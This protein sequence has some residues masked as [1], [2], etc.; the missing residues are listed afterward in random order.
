MDLRNLLGKL[1]LIEGT[2]TSAEK[3]S[4]GPKFTGQWKGTDA[5]TPGKK[6][7][8]DSI[9]KD[10]SKGPKPKT[11][12]Q[13]LAEQFE[14]FL[15]QLEEDN[16][17]VE[18]KRPARKG[19]RPAREYTKNGQP[20]KRYTPVKEDGEENDPHPYTPID[21]GTEMISKFRQELE[22]LQA[23]DKT[24]AEKQAIYSYL[25][26]KFSKE[27]EAY[28]QSKQV[29]EAGANNPPQQATS[30]SPSLGQQQTGQ[31]DPKQLAQTNQ[32]LSAIKAGTGSS[33]PTT[34]IAKALDA[35]SQ[36][37]PVGQQDMKALEPMM[38]DIATVAQDPKLA[39]QFKTLAQQI[40]QVQKNQQNTQSSTSS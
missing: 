33:A 28:K 15:A 11:K 23:S 39:G 6:L 19:A 13:D 36:G 35:A 1:T 24:P 12:E 37:K 9:L 5:G 26:D 40:Q 31:P 18:E 27:A 32:A 38:Q 17:G 7:V 4:T 25:V 10:L 21:E 20:S 3:N 34:N 14:S 29:D 8:G 2:M 22:A 16:L 30:G